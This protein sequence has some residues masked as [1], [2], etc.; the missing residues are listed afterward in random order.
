MEPGKGK[1]E[2]TNTSSPWGP[3][4][5]FLTAGMNQAKT[6]LGKSTNVS[7]NS[8]LT[9]GENA[10]YKLGVNAASNPYLQ[11][12]GHTAS[13]M[14]GDT[15]G[16]GSDAYYKSV[17]SG[18]YLN[19]NPYIDKMYGQAAGQVE[20]G[21]NSMAS[22]AG[23][24]GSGLHQDMLTHALNDLATNIYGQNYANER[25]NQQAAA[26]GL[27]QNQLGAGSQRLQAA[28]ML[29]GIYGAQLQGTQAAMGVG[30]DIQ[31]QLQAQQME[32]WERLAN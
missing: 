26:A 17:L 19:S 3:Q 21:T 24:Y 31:N 7:P 18:D 29:P 14:A 16:M 12:A 1:T 25:Q 27:T 10:L 23:R 13:Q 9:G 11:T 22:G 8:Y 4:I 2:T 15:S 6:L 20:A 32:P 30:K 28:G 5:P